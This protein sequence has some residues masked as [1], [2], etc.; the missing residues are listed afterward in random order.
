MIH[1]LVLFKVNADVD[2]EKIEWMMRETRIQ[3]LKIPEVAS[4]RCGKRVESGNE[5]PFF[6]AVELESLD[7]LRLYRD[8]PIHVKYVEEVIK[9]HTSERLA[10]DYEIEPGR[11][12]RYS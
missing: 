12:V 10:L 6:L 1:H 4:V 11:D 8:D 9:P 3:L 5:W 7:K 2:E